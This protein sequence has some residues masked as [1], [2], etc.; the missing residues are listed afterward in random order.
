M[1]VIQSANVRAEGKYTREGGGA[2]TFQERVDT[3]EEMLALLQTCFGQATHIDVS[4]FQK[5]NEEISSD[6]TL[7]ILSLL[8]ERLPCSEN[9]WRYRRN[10]ELHKEL[11]S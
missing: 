2:Q 10:F 1:P 7:S 9:Y 5:I 3:L 11:H 6:M 4:Q 8:R